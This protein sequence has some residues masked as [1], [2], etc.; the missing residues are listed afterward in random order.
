MVVVSPQTG[1]APLTVMF[2]GTGSTAVS[3][4]I[5]SWRWDFGDGTTGS[6]PRVT[7]V[8]HVVGDYYAHLKVTDSRGRINLVPLLHHIVAAAPG[9]QLANISTRMSVGTG[10]NVLIGGFIV[11]GTERKK[12]IVRAI[13]PELGAP[14]YNIPNAL[15][16]PI[17]ELHDSS[18]ALL[19]TNDNWGDS[20]YSRKSLRRRFRH[21]M[22]R[23]PPS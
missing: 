4:R 19:A 16:D 20:P 2:N 5:M 15:A 11:K 7:H 18:G 14:P 8:Y 13:G 3:G 23:N 22:L 1:A 17:L 6:G 21:R 12:V 10:D 9:A